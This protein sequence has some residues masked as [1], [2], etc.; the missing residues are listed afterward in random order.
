MEMKRERRHPAED[1]I[2]LSGNIVMFDT[3]LRDG[4][5]SPR[6]SFSES[7][8]MAIAEALH[9]LEVDVVEIGTPAASREEFRIA[10][11][12]CAIM[13]DRTIAVLAKPVRRDIEASL[14]AVASSSRVRL[15][16]YISTSPQQMAAQGMHQDQVLET[17]TQSVSFAR[18]HTDDVEWSSEDATR[19]DQEFLCR[20]I[21]AA[22]MAGATTINLPDSTGWIMPSEYRSLFE[23]VRAR[24]PGSERAVFSV[25]CHNDLGLALANTLAGVQGGARQIECTLQG[26]GARAGNAATGDV[27]HL[28]RARPDALPYS[29]S[30]NYSAMTDA[31]DLVAAIVRGQSRLSDGS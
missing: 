1:M 20:C 22:I 7:Q 24:V 28:I 3:T 9:R 4:A 2:K 31:D 18:N 16:T 30:I 29:L 5:H 23:A 15:H 25:H 21:E 6:A 12:I 26:L 19:S 27:L 10:S 11:K 17:I 8:K 13:T 14:E